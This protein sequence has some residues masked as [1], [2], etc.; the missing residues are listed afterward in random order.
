MSNTPAHVINITELLRDGRH[1]AEV[2]GDRVHVIDSL[3]GNTYVAYKDPQD[4]T[5]PN[6]FVEHVSPTGVKVWIEEGAGSEL[7]NTRA[8]V[9]FS[10]HI[11]SVISQKIAEGGALTRICT[12]DGMPRYAQLRQW[13]RTYTWIDEE[14]DRARRDRA[15]ALRDKALM[16]A[17]NAVSKDPIDAHSLRVD[18]Y[19]WGA[20]V[21]HEKYNPKT[22]VEATVN[23]PTQIVVFTGIDR[24]PQVREVGE[25]PPGVQEHEDEK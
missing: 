23:T 13:A 2:R 15:E 11:I 7:S 19:K 18:T 21:D 25:I 5:V 3:T 14:L 16:E 9:A 4:G 20:S 6:R 1:F 8:E 17:E 12:E 22:K 24:T 10:P